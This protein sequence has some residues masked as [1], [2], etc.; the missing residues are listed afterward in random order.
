MWCHDRAAAAQGS[1]QALKY[2]K[3]DVK[4]TI[5]TISVQELGQ[6]VDTEAAFLLSWDGAGGEQVAVL[7]N[8]NMVSNANFQVIL[9]D[10]SPSAVSSK[11]LGGL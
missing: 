5:L 10:P 2:G 4:S 11:L 3:D 8:A 7:C 9:M 1:E 6:S